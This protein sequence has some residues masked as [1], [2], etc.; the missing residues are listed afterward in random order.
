MLSFVRASLTLLLPQKV[1]AAASNGTVGG[2]KR[3]MPEIRSGW[4]HLSSGG[5]KLCEA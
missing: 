5:T 3:P 2:V 4:G 1:Q